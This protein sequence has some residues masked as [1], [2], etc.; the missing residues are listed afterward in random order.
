MVESRRLLKNK[1]ATYNYLLKYV[2]P[3]ISGCVAH[4]LLTRPEQ[5]VE[6]EMYRYLKGA[7]AT[8]E[9]AET[10]NEVTHVFTKR[11]QRV[12]LASK[13][14]P[15][16]KALMTQLAVYQPLNV[17]DFICA[18]LQ[19]MAQAAGSVIESI[20]EPE[21]TKA[22]VGTTKRPQT[23]RKLEDAVAMDKSIAQTN[24]T[25]ERPTTAPSSSSSTK[26][27][28]VPAEQKAQP[29]STQKIIQIAILGVGNA[30]KTSIINTLQGNKDAATK[31]TLGFRPTT[32]MLG[33]DTKIK[34]YD[35]GG[36]KKIRDIWEQYYHDV[37]AAVYVVDSSETT[38]THWDECREVFKNVYNHSLLSG[39]PLLVV[40]NKQDVAGSLD[41]ET[42]CEN[43][44]FDTNRNRNIVP[45][46]ALGSFFQSQDAE[47]VP[48]ERSTPV[49]AVDKRLEMGLEWLISVISGS[50][51]ELNS[52]VVNDTKQKDAEEA[53]KRLERERKVLRN[54]IASAFF[55]QVAVEYRPENVDPAG[56]EDI[57]GEEDGVKFLADEI[58]QEVG[59]LPQEAID[60]ANMIGYQR[61]ALQMVG[62]LNA[63]INKKKVPMSWVE[64]KQLVTEL[65]RELHLE[66]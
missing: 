61:L 32:M 9:P 41:V 4:L 48:P 3:V 56:T 20:D 6:N 58:G 47:D 46:S 57:Y 35:L 16:L 22:K 30:G 7:I 34:F 63:P 2:D 37:H 59:A 55:H 52:R 25:L 29:V 28:S 1:E 54:K 27:P 8:S 10:S 24:A 49:P 45:C 11:E 31:P 51:D 65:R 17:T 42:V 36:G 26:P 18:E 60:V 15:I 12:Y 66:Q 50:F 40:A 21:V 33:E 23:A 19:S 14:S 5:C 39:K 44:G 43:L 13:V 38:E 62:A 53:R 64:I